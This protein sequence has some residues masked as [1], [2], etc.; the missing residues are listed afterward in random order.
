M[1][2]PPLIENEEDRLKALA[3]YGLGPDHPLPSLEPVV[4]IAASIGVEAVDMSRRVSFC[5]H[6][7]T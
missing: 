6:A 7:I 5:A 2:C 3:Y 1:E 4:Q